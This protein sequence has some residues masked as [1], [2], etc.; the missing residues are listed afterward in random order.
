MSQEELEQQLKDGLMVA[1]GPSALEATNALVAMDVD[2]KHILEQV[3][4]VSMFDLGE[5]WKR[6]EVFLPEVVASAEVFKQCNAIV[7]PIL[8][9]GAKEQANLKVIMFTVKGDLHDLGKNMVAAMMR[10]AGMDVTD[11]GKDTPTE[12]AL[13]AVKEITPDIVGMSALLTTTVGQQ[14]VIIKALK[15]EG[16]RDTV[17]VMVGGAPVTQEWADE[18][19]ADGYAPSAPEAVNKAKELTGRA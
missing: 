8:V 6:G 5:K 3:M 1:N 9:A 19:G 11:L 12:K 18:I 2:P 16:L 7:E 14:G 4:A 10:T 15:K 13:N 17:K